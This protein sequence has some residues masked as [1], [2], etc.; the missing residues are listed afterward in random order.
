VPHPYL[1]HIYQKD[2]V[3]RD[4]YTIPSESD[5]FNIGLFGGS[6]AANLADYEAKTATIEKILKQRIPELR[7]RK[8]HLINFALGYGAQPRQATASLLYGRHLNL[9]VNLEGVNEMQKPMIPAYPNYFPKLELGELFYSV[10][11]KNLVKTKSVF[12]DV[13]TV[14][15]LEADLV[16]KR[17]ISSLWRSYLK[18]RIMRLYDS[19]RSFVLALEE[20]S[21]VSDIP[22]A[23]LEDVWTH[24]VEDQT[25]IFA[26]R[27]IPFIAFVQPAFGA[28]NVKPLSDLENEL[29]KSFTQ[30]RYETIQSQLNSGY[31]RL[32][33]I[34]GL[35]VFN[36]EMIFRQT[37]ETTYIDSC[38]H[39]NEL[40]NQMLSQ[41]IANSISDSLVCTAKHCA[42]K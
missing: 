38:C 34:P 36:L 9:A 41:A 40:G 7:N 35:K 19:L 29:G 42:L 8:I 26:A 24:A 11:A 12:V 21:R 13:M 22:V 2:A 20:R 23:A 10:D 4:E 3:K 30:E 1:G 5:A 39:L 33:Q 16:E 6:V 27:K 31:Q 28:R 37:R 25:S 14:H 15:A 18:F 32:R 17:P